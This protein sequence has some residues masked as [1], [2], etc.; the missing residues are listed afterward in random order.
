[1]DW[2][3]IYKHE[4]HSIG[5]DKLVRIVK[6]NADHT[7]S[8]EG[9]PLTMNWRITEDHSVQVNQFPELTASR[10]TSSDWGWDLENYYVLLSNIAKPTTKGYK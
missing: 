9:I 6:F 10:R 8:T 2:Q 1:M 5:S 7:C 4:L 3:L